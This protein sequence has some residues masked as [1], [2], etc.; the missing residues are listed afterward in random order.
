MSLLSCGRE[1]AEARRGSALPPAAPRPRSAAAPALSP[2]GGARGPGRSGAAGGG[3]RGCGASRIR[4]G[5]PRRGAGSGCCGARGPPAPC[6]GRREKPVRA[7]RK[8]PAS[9]SR[10]RKPEPGS[11]QLQPEPRRCRETHLRPRVAQCASAR[12]AEPPAAPRDAHLF[13]IHQHV[14]GAQ[15]RALDN[16][17]T[18][19]LRRE[20]QEV[21]APSVPFPGAPGSALGTG[22]LRVK[23]CGCTRE[24]KQHKTA[25][26]GCRWA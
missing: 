6:A 26:L 5:F 1:A 21:T 22:V 9:V 16:G 25:S 18:F 8:V 13:Q 4:G 23:H 3:G 11:A 2:A 10:R 14:V 15:L 19:Q 24:A 7:G 12:L 20:D 17:V